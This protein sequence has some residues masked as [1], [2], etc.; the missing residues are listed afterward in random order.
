MDVEYERY[1]SIVWIQLIRYH[2]LMRLHYEF[3]QFFTVKLYIKLASIVLS[4]IVIVQWQRQTTME[5]CDQ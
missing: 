4:L 1:C 3:D 2:Q 5:L